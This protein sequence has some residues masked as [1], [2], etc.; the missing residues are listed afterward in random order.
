LGFKRVRWLTRN[1]PKRAGTLFR[2][3]DV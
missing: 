2:V 3:A 1:A